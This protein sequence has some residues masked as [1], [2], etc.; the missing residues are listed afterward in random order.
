M[1]GHSQ[2]LDIEMQTH[3]GTFSPT[4]I[5]A[6]RYYTAVERGGR[7]LIGQRWTVILSSDV[8]PSTTQKEG[9]QLAWLTRSKPSRRLGSHSQRPTWT[10]GWPLGIPLIFF[11]NGTNGVPL[12][13]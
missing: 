13:R 9:S 6:A 10:G 7:C 4:T 8:N 5:K 3:P 11:R 1:G 2:P 12:R